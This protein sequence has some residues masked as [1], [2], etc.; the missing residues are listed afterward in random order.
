MKLLDQNALEFLMLGFHDSDD[1]EIV[2]LDQIQYVISLFADGA[3]VKN[4]EM[5]LTFVGD[6]VALHAWME[7]SVFVLVA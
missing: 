7:V 5:E 6:C 3:D 2:R 4:I 1:M